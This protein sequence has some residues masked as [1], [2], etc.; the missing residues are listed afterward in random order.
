MRSFKIFFEIF[1]DARSED[2]GF[3][4]ALLRKWEEVQTLRSPDET[5]RPWQHWTLDT[6]LA[7]SAFTVKWTLADL[8][9]DLHSLL[10]RDRQNTDRKFGEWKGWRKNYRDIFLKLYTFYII[11]LIHT[12]NI[13]FCWFFDFVL[14]GHKNNVRSRNIIF[15]YSTNGHGRGGVLDFH[16]EIDFYDVFKYN[17]TDCELGIISLPPRI[18]NPHVK[19]PSRVLADAQNE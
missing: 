7:A 3:N 15:N 10:S 19:H 6:S 11:P 1:L 4:M 14:L 12:L 17:Y 13:L 16:I 8:L 2:N 9:D 5:L 18:L